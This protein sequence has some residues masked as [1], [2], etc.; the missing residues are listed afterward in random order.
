MSSDGGMVRPRALAL[1]MLITSSNFVGRSTGR[2]A[3]LGPLPERKLETGAGGND[4][5]AATRDRQDGRARQKQQAE[6]P[7]TSG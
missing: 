3:G 1:F 2:S 7:T 5:P 4:H 6:K